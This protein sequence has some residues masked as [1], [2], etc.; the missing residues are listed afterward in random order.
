MGDTWYQGFPRE[1]QSLSSP[2][3]LTWIV[4]HV[5]FSDTMRAL[6]SLLFGAGLVLMASRGMTK[7]IYWRRNVFLIL[8]GIAH[9][10]LFMWAGEI[11]MIYGVCA[12]LLFPLRNANTKTLMWLSIVL[13]C[14]FTLLASAGGL[15][16]TERYQLAQGGLA[17]QELGNALTEEQQ[18]ALD[19]WANDPRSHPIGPEEFAQEEATRLSGYFANVKLS[20]EQFI[21]FQLYSEESAGI[22]LETV[23]TVMLGM[24]LFGAGVISGQRSLSFYRNMM[25][26]GYAIGLTLRTLTT[27]ASW[28]AGVPNPV[29]F[30]FVVYEPARIATALGHIGLFF[31]LFFNTSGSRVWLALARMGQMALTSYIGQSLISAALFFGFGFALFGKL[32]W[33]ELTLLAA[34]VLVFQGI[35]SFYWLTRYRFGPFEWLWRSLTYW[36]WQALLKSKG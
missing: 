8:F 20:T 32:D 23:F 2:A 18:A 22:V 24:A 4:T 25:L 13:L 10:T 14:G 16:A 9:G 21:E 19:D 35:V 11:L 29:W 28:D 7:S 34:V 12:V 33:F 27:S 26:I 1:V 36:K 3:W 15:V 17:Q 31:V 30:E 6:F 5:F